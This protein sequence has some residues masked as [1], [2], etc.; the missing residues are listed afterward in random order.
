MRVS[1]TAAFDHWLMNAQHQYPYNSLHATRNSIFCKWVLLTGRSE[2][3]FTEYFPVLANCF[4]NGVLLEMI[5]TGVA[6]PLPLSLSEIMDGIFTW[7]NINQH[8]SHLMV[9]RLASEL[10]GGPEKDK[11]G[12]VLSLINIRVYDMIE[13]CFGETMAFDL[14]YV[15]WIQW[16]NG[17]YK[18]EFFDGKYCFRAI[19]QSSFE[20]VEGTIAE[21]NNSVVHPVGVNS[22]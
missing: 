15:D 7:G 18:K 8:W 12:M 14:V 6:K 2:F 22:A 19:A 5:R 3:G 4:S 16:F 1:T 11:R 10:E 17:T 13:E 20:Y 21:M 9:N